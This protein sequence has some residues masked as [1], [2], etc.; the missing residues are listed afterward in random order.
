MHNIGPDSPEDQQ[1]ELQP[2]GED[3]QPEFTAGSIFAQ[4]ATNKMFL[5]PEGN[6]NQSAEQPKEEEVY[7][8]EDDPTMFKAHGKW[9]KFSSK[10]IFLF[11]K[12]NGY[13][14]CVVSIITNKRFD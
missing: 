7:N 1:I 11:T 9:H 14:K 10:S 4:F 2:I 6:K 5:D 12:E 13:R 8:P 3:F